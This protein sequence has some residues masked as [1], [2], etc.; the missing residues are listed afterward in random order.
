M[1]ESRKYII[2]ALVVVTGFIFISKLFAIQVLSGE[3]KD[4]AESNIILE[5]IEYP[6]R[7]LLYD[8][9]GDHLVVNEPEFDL[10]VTPKDV[11]VRDTAA[12]CDLL[13]LTAEEFETKLSEA[14]S[15]SYVKA[16]IFIK[17]I[18]LEEYGSIQDFLVDY[19][20]FQIRARTSRSYP[21]GLMSN[22]LGYIAEVS[23][24][25]LEQDAENYYQQGDYI[26]KSGLESSYEEYLRG[27]RG[28]RYKIK[29][30]SG[31]AQGDFK[32]GRFDTLAVPGLDLYTTIDSELQQYAETLLRGKV[33]SVVA[34]EPATGGILAMV[35]SPFYD[36]N[37]L[38][39]RDFGTNFAELQAD[40][41]VP[42]FNR[43]IMAMYPP[44][45]IFKIVQ[46]LIGLQEGVI[47][48]NEV[49]YIDGMA[50]GDHAPPGLYDLHEAIKLSSNNYF[51]KMYRRI[52]N[53]NLHENTFIDSRLGL[54]NWYEHVT[55][56]GFGRPLGIDIPN[57]KGGLM[58]DST[59]YD[60]MYGNKR[61]KFSTVASLSIGQGEMLLSPLQMANL[62]A[63]VANRGH[64]YTPH[65]VRG[66]GEDGSPLPEYTIKNDVGIDPEYFPVVVD[67]MED[68]VR[69]TA[70]RA[71]I[72]DVA[73]CAKTGTAENPHGEDHSVFMAFA[74]KD[75]PKIAISVYVENAGWGGRA[76]ASTASLVIERYLKGEISRPW[77]EEYVL[78]GDFLDPK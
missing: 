8:R 64:Y 38:T 33:G 53:Q 55:A 22:A 56:F 34:I 66:I 58:P 78:A 6:Y 70:W 68:V 74:P 54:Q 65:L 57:E 10:L 30:V 43:P 67:A 17:Q 13:N 47:N 51:F 26:G 73:V 1:I 18:P 75:D 59:Y 46:A 41:L 11:H 12:F 14:R 39:G 28:K 32:D 24:Q 25:E 45:S 16:S 61:W 29:N 77:L 4:A 60:R 50:I 63:I 21:N 40:T 62:A 71:V 44:G 2:Q 3:Y 9:H 31:V 37:S 35:S 36:P 23:P 20:G 69:G 27:K 19:P 48:P 7:G 49:I 76:A 52:L 5:V 15:Y 72:P 42:L